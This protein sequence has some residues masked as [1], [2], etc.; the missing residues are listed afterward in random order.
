[1]SYISKP[2]YMLNPAFNT[3]EIQ[4]VMD[5]FNNSWLSKQKL[6]EDGQL[7]HYTTL[8]GIQGILKDRALWHSHSSTLNDPLEIQYGH[9]LISN[10]L[11]YSME[12]EKREDLRSFLRNML[13]NFQD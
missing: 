5:A 10:I 4:D 7:F 2:L 6:P 13:I 9:K 1:M 12:D 3:P 8:S 11:R